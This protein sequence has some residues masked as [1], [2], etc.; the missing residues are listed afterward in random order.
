MHR[1]S[2]CRVSHLYDLVAL[3][4]ILVHIGMR[5]EIDSRIIGCLELQSQ[6]AART[7]TDSQRERASDLHLFQSTVSIRCQ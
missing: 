4:N 1:E 7:F 3:E 6:F 5:L 2:S